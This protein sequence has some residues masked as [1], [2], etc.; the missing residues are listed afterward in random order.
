MTGKVGFRAPERILGRCAIG[1]DR[2]FLRAWVVVIVP[3]ARVDV[4]FEW[5][6]GILRAFRELSA[7][8]W[9]HLFVLGRKQH[10]DG[11]IGTILAFHRVHPA[12]GVFGQSCAE[13]VLRFA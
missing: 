13:S 3:R 11:G 12:S 1:W 9:V 8:L 5:A 7:G 6:A 2:L 10:Q 4:G